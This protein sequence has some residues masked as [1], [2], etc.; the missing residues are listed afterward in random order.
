MRT[1]LSP[2]I[3]AEIFDTSFGA[4]SALIYLPSSALDFK[5]SEIR[6]YLDQFVRG[7]NGYTA[8][9]GSR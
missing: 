2:K 3:R 9:T 1:L 5:V 8:S 4:I 7:S 6:R